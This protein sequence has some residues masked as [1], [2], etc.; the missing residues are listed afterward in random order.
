MRRVVLGVVLAATALVPASAGPASAPPGAVAHLEAILDRSP[1]PEYRRAGSAG[2]AAVADYEAGVLTGAGYQVVRQDF[3]LGSARYGVD[4]AAGHEPLLERVADG[5]RFKVDSAFNLTRQTPPEGIECTVRA[6]ADVRPGDCGF[7]PF[8]TAS[9]EWK[10]TSANLSGA[11]KQIVDQGGAGAV[12]QGDVP[13]N[14]VMAVSVRQAL[15]SVVAVAAPEDLIGQRV[16]LRAMRDTAASTAGHNVIGVRPGPP[17][18]PYV[19]LLAH[20]DGWY[21][22]AADNGGGAAA[23][24]RAA[25]LLAARQPGIGV[26]AALMD[27][28]EIGLIGSKRL[29]D[30]LK[31]PGGLALPGGGSLKM[32]DLAAAINLDAS[33]A[34][35][36]DAQE[37]VHQRAGVDV[38]LFS[39]RAMVYS[40]HAT[41]PSL[42]LATFAQHGVLG[43]PLTSQ[44][45]I[46]VNGSWRTDAGAFHDAGVPV[47]WPVAGYPEYHTDADTLAVVDPADLEAI[48]EASADL[49]GRLVGVPR[50]PILA[51]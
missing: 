11:A 16:R 51:P 46:A 9:P 3:D 8:A 6:I 44:A 42:F 7:V 19:L 10:N 14:A 32:G 45:A 20:A 27:G 5:H 34:R 39:W 30:T 28:E 13:R 33:S 49:V 25:E 2:M 22:A 1:A 38:P 24:L 47:V 37:P 50:T 18:S 23:V 12:V 41:L 31:A 21:Q 43:L 17:G 48:A 36:S 26:V 4:Y 29:A 35:A 15:P 40:V